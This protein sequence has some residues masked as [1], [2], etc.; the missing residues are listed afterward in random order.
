MVAI[1]EVIALY[2]IKQYYY[3]VGDEWREVNLPSDN[4]DLILLFEDYYY[5]CSF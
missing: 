1:K 4:N 3:V 5:Y 2:P